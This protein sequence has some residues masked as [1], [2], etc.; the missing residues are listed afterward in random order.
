MTSFLSIMNGNRAPESWLSICILTMWRRVEEPISQIWTLPSCRRLGVHCCGQVYWTM[1]PQQRT[2]EPIIRH[3]QKKE[4]SLEV[5]VISSVAYF[6]NA[7]CVKLTFF[8]SSFSKHVVS[9]SRLQDPTQ[10]FLHMKRKVYEC[11]EIL[12]MSAGGPLK[13]FSKW[14]C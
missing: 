14:R 3:F 5:S 2:I 10:V 7:H 4:S 9:S 11:N 13:N 1:I 12:W 6:W 8:V